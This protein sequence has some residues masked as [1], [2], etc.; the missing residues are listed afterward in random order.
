M[1]LDHVLLVLRPLRAEHEAEVFTPAPTPPGQNRDCRLNFAGFGTLAHSVD[2][3]MSISLT[4]LVAHL[5][6][7]TA[8]WTSMNWPSTLNLTSDVCG[9]SNSFLSAIATV[10]PSPSPL[11]ATRATVVGRP[12][13]SGSAPPPPPPYALA[14]HSPTDASL[15]MT[16]GEAKLVK[17]SSVLSKCVRRG[18]KMNWPR[19]RPHMYTWV[20][21]LAKN[22]HRSHERG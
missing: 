17:T 22:R 9:L 21:G 10:V 3:C 6:F 1:D 13:F 5:I 16:G 12:P 14:S 8:L 4:A 7:S 2:P 15:H 11:P 19:H 20:R 18:D